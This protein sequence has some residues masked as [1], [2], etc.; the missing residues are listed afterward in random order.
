MAER[1]IDM[2]RVR[3]AVEAEGWDAVIEHTGGGVGTLFV[4]E[5]ELPRGPGRLFRVVCG[6]FAYDGATAHAGELCIGADDQG[7]TEPTI[8]T[9]ADTEDSVV[10]EILAQ[11]TDARA[12]GE[13]K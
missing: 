11:V 10:D 4:G 8:C 9:E 13:R 1:T 12:P 6:P 3:Q 5:L 2:E 7:E